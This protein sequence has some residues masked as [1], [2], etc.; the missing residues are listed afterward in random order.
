[1]YISAVTKLNNYNPSTNPS[2]S[3]S[4]RQN[5]GNYR[6]R[7]LKQGTDNTLIYHCHKVKGKTNELYI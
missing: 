6:A 1:M 7:Q 2:E 4:K 3:K 5:Y